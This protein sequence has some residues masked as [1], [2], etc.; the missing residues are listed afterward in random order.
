MC[1]YCCLSSSSLLKPRSNYVRFGYMNFISH[2]IYP[3]VKSFHR[4]YFFKFIF[5]TFIH[6]LFDLPFFL[7]DLLTYIKGFSS[8]TLLPAWVWHVRTIS[9]NSSHNYLSLIDATS[10][11]F[12]KPSIFIISFS[13]PLSNF[14]RLCKKQATT[15]SIACF[16]LWQRTR[17][18]QFNQVV[19]TRECSVIRKTSCLHLT[20]QRSKWATGIICVIMASGPSSLRSR[21]QVLHPHEHMTLQQMLD[22]DRSY[23]SY[24]KL[25]LLA[26]A[27]PLK[28]KQPLVPK[29]S[30]SCR[31]WPPA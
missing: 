13:I 6:V 25:H 10:K 3:I 29:C 21:C 19:Q 14:A 12:G 20:L 23:K 18:V 27:L 2:S 5:T 31:G 1:N 4:L 28:C 26:V 17:Q 11:Y 9:N 22:A 7:Y 24:A 15:W 30:R 16:W 8:S